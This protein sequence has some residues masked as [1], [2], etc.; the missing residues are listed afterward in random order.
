MKTT[1]TIGQDAETGAIVLCAV[2]YC[3]GR[4]TYMPGL[5]TDWVRRHWGE[6]PVKDRALILRDVEE[7]V[8]WHKSDRL[9]LGHDCDVQTWTSFLAWMKAQIQLGDLLGEDATARAIASANQV[10]GVK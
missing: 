9:S 10:F 1:Q 7:A 4:Q 6:L 3:L 8:E 2:R 5:V